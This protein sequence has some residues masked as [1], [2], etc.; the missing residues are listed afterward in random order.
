MRDALAK[1]YRH[2]A[3]KHAGRAEDLTYRAI[4]HRDRA[5]HY[6]AKADDVLPEAWSD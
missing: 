2:R 3:H 6:E 4:F 1:L 5:N